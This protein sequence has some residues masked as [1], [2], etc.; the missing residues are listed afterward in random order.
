M[1]KKENGPTP[2]LHTHGLPIRDRGP[3]SAGSSRLVDVPTVNTE[4]VSDLLFL[5]DFRRNEYFDIQKNRQH[6]EFY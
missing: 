5:H 2:G 3:A 6:P 1:T 4:K